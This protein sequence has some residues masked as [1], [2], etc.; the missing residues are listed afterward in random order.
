MKNKRYFQANYLELFKLFFSPKN[1]LCSLASPW[2]QPAPCPPAAFRA[3]TAPVRALRGFQ[4][5]KRW[6]PV[7][8][9]LGFCLQA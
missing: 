8:L 1:D 4:G 9:M 7:S 6:T 5:L 2:P 3:A